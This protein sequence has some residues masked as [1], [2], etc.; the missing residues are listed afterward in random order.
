[1]RSEKLGKHE[2]EHKKLMEGLA[3]QLVGDIAKSLT[4]DEEQATSLVEGHLIGPRTAHNGTVALAS[5]PDANRILDA[6]WRKRI[7]DSQKAQT[8]DLPQRE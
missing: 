1:M 7:R 6:Q 8:P 2:L 5:S 3:K 4:I